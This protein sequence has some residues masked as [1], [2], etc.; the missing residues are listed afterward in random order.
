[1]LSKIERK[2]VMLMNPEEDL[3]LSWKNGFINSL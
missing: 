2:R 1:M 3:S